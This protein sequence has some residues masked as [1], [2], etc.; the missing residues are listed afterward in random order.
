VTL[1]PDGFEL[2]E[3]EYTYSEVVIASA[4]TGMDDRTFPRLHIMVLVSR[5]PTYAMVNLM[6]P[7]TCLV[8][9]GFLQFTIPIDAVGERI[10]VTLTLLLTAAAYR[11]AISTMVP[12]VSYLTMLDKYVLVCSIF[13]MAMVIEN[14]IAG[15]VALKKDMK[16]GEYLDI[17]SA[18]VL[19]VF[20]GGF[21]VWFT[22]VVKG[23]KRKGKIMNE[24]GTHKNWKELARISLAEQ[25]N[26]STKVTNEDPTPRTWRS[27]LSLSSLFSGSG[28]SNARLLPNGDSARNAAVVPSED[29]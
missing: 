2:V 22:C 27:R 7:M 24:Q 19:L 13:I 10:A 11:Y 16:A 21:H 1:Q 4:D 3:S 26:A 12:M 23:A 18:I 6:L 9:L 29:A 14:G 8:V 20:F 5:K 15:T 28:T 17:A 25:A